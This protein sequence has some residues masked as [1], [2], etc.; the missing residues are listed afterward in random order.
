[1]TGPQLQ[2]DYDSLRDRVEKIDFPAVRGTIPVVPFFQF[3]GSPI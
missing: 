3:R 1:M 2:R